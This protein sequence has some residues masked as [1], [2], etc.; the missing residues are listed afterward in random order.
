MHAV[1][2]EFD[3]NYAATMTAEAYARSA[4]L[5]C[6]YAYIYSECSSLLSSASASCLHAPTH[7]PFEYVTICDRYMHGRS[8]SLGMPERFA[9]ASLWRWR[10]KYE[11]PVYMTS[12]NEYGAKPPSQQMLP[13]SWHGAKGE[14][15]KNYIKAE[16]RTGNFS[17]G[18][19]TSRVHDA[20][21]EL[22]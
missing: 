11:H 16:V 2:Q 9:D 21:T 17:T 14:F 5:A 22:C 8:G 13:L 19:P 6:S 12:N 3:Q 1:L 15:T 20:L 18:M 10:R 7:F 4:S